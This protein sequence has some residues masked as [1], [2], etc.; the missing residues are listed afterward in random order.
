MT[1]CIEHSQVRM[2]GQRVLLWD[3][4]W[5]TAASTARLFVRL[6]FVVALFIFGGWEVART[7]DGYKGMGR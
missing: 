2:C 6:S 5:H 1:R 7:K 3:T 4:L